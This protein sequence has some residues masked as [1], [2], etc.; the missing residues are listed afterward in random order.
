MSAPR[1]RPAITRSVVVRSRSTS[2]GFSSRLRKGLSVLA[3]QIRSRG[4]A[5]AV[6]IQ[7]E[8]VILTTLVD[9]TAR[10]R[11]EEELRRRMEE[12]RATNEDLARFNRVAVDRELRMVELKKQ[13]NE[14]CQKV[15]LA[16]R[17][18]VEEEES[19]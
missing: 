10:K 2:L 1:S 8:N 7:G 11:A 6:T 5:P 9:I 4:S 14:L 17:Y 13:I 16:K 18:D 3:S 15:G 19:H 12:L